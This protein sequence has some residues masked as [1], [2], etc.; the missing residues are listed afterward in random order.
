MSLRAKILVPL[1]SIALL[2]GLVA[3][4]L[5]V[6]R[7]EKRAAER[8][9]EQRVEQ[10]EVRMMQSLLNAAAEREVEGRD[11]EA[12]AGPTLPPTPSRTAS[13]RP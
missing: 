9:E 8:R 2:P 12:D 6:S 7:F 13:S 3:M 1:A 4:H 11:H 10:D 5:E